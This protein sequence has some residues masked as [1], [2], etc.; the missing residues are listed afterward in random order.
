MID[1]GRLYSKNDIGR[2][3]KQSEDNRFLVD[4]NNCGNAKVEN[5]GL[6]SINQNNC[7]EVKQVFEEVKTEFEIG[8]EVWT[9]QSGW[10]KIKN[11]N[12]MYYPYLTEAGVMYTIEGKYHKLD[13]YPSIYKG[14]LNCI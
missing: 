10:T 12:N 11:N 14:E 5:D 13:K 4:F 2:V 1:N 3:I 6:W 8:E 7:V 9:I